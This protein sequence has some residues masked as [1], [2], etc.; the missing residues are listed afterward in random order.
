M[1]NGRSDR[2]LGFILRDELGRRLSGLEDDDFAMLQG[3]R[4]AD[5]TFAQGQPQDDMPVGRLVAPA[6][7]ASERHRR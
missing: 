2:E 6:F 4:R 5:P 7:A 3:V 1:R